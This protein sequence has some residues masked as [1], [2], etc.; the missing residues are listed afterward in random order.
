MDW[1]RLPLLEGYIT[2]AG[3]GAESLLVA[4]RLALVDYLSESSHE[5]RTLNIC[6][7]LTDLLA[8]NV[9][10][11]RLAV[12]VLEVIA[13]LFEAQIYQSLAES[14]TPFK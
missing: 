8:R 4:S 9:A 14:G 1:L 5:P 2:S 6:N 7:D 11:E 12:P 13:F 10:N 3:V